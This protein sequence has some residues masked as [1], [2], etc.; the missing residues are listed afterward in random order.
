MSQLPLPIDW[1]E[2]GETGSLLI[3]AANA[4]AI[5]LLRDWRRWPSPAT[6]LVG[7]PKSGRSLIGRLFA[8]ESGGM[9]VDDADKADETALFNL[10]NRA[11]DERQTLLLI[12]AAPPP[13]WAVR[14]PDLRTRLATAA[15]ARIA[16]P[17]EAVTTALIAHGLERA[18]SAFAPG[19]PEFIA[20]RVTR[21]YKTADKVVGALNAESLASARK[22]TI[23]SARSVL[24]QAGLLS[25]EPVEG[26]ESEGAG[27]GG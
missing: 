13:L 6:L 10:W 21:C 25:S 20:R 17:D 23:A 4:D 16:E 2:R 22:L 3:T 9:L 12:A 27:T 15:V 7:P 14:L 8:A 19:L 11:R 18:G 1:S 26:D 24:G 5:A